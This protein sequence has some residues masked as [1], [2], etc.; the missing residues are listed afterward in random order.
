MLAAHG[1]LA[2]VANGEEL[3]PRFHLA[4]PVFASDVASLP[5]ALEDVVG[6]VKRE[7]ERERERAAVRC[8]RAGQ[9]TSRCLLRSQP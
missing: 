8:A 9:R 1:H 3:F 2:K 4:D 5:E 7:T 6:K